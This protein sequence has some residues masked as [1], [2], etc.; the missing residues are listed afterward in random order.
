MIILSESQAYYQDL[1]D[2]G[3]TEQDAE[4]YTKKYY[5]EFKHDQQATDK[6]E[7][8]S[9][10]VLE[11]HE[12]N[13]Y[14]PSP[15]AEK[16]QIIS[17]EVK[18]KLSGGMQFIT[19]KANIIVRDK[20][21]A[22]GAGIAIITVILIAVIL[23][24]PATSG[25][26]EGTWVKAD[27]QTFEFQQ[28]GDLEDGNSFTST[29]DYEGSVLTM[30]SKTLAVDSNN[31]IYEMTIVQKFNVE[32]ID[33]E[34]AMWM[35]WVALEIDGEQSSEMSNQCILMIREN[36]ASNAQE[37][38]TLSIEYENDKPNWC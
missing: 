1:L 21:L 22:I 15:T 35:N 5:P 6:V 31:Q 13:P 23:L 30:T 16:Q 34:N 24:I 17:Q 11:N 33:D 12:F 2:Q 36:V 28:D 27:G 29:W 4:L 26:I 32:L 7:A 8:V 18:D 37:F 3:Y 10:G 19:E 20:R 38:Y 25:P 9:V 14:V